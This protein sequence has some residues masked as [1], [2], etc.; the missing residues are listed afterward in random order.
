[1]RN[2]ILLLLLFVLP[3]IVVCQNKT[4]L[5][6]QLWQRVQN[7][8]SLF[9]PNEDGILEYNKIDDSKNGYLRVWGSFPTCGCT[10]SSTIGA[11]KDTNGIYTFLQKE[12]FLCEYR[13]SISSNKDLGKILPEN[14]GI[15]TFLKEELNISSD[16]AVFF[17]DVEIP[18]FGTDTKFTLQLIPFGILQEQKDSVISYS[19]SQENENTPVQYIKEIEYMANKI[20]DDSTLTY[21]LKKNYESIHI[22]DRKFIENAL[23]GQDSMGYF[24]S[25]DELSEKLNI[26][27]NAYDIYSQLECM[28]VLM[29]W[30]K[31]KAR[32]EIKSKSD[33]PKTMTFKEFLLENVYWTPIC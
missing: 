29:Q 17:L 12:E 21:L 27:K 25:F 19:Y 30:N 32:F 20:I 26:L 7:C 24:D 5:E 8:Y 33:E 16:Y 3:H 10:C 22:D 28:S 14:F 15:H 1:M 18:R 4:N 23:V 13:K 11:Y 31:E 6:K 9:E 2:T